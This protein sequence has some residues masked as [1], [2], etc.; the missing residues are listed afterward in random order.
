MKLLTAVAGLTI[1][2]GCANPFL[3]NYSGARFPA[4][5]H[6][7]IMMTHP[8]GQTPIGRSEFI[9]TQM[10]GD[11]EA[12]DAAKEVGA[13]AV[14]WSKDYL[15]S[16]TDLTTRVQPVT[17]NTTTT[18]VGDVNAQVTT[19]QTDYQYIPETRT[20]H[21]WRYEAAFYRQPN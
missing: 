14:V 4:T 3:E 18:I 6:A 20:N 17:S 10:L 21:W 19:T 1:L 2:S 9:A 16:T 7:V 8:E 15:N 11:R 13:N 5:D 12:I